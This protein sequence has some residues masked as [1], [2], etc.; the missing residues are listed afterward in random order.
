MYELHELP[1]EYR[2]MFKVLELTFKA[3]RGL[4]S[5]GKNLLVIPWPMRNLAGLFFFFFAM[6]PFWQ[7]SLLDNVLWKLL[8]F[9][10]TCKAE[11]LCQTFT[12]S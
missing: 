10:R 3:I 7:N 2:I 5:K 11:T 8:P 9:L 12:V 1:V 4:C 6:T